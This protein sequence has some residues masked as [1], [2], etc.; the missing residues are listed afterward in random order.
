[1]NNV[2]FVDI[3]RN[4][5]PKME[6]LHQAACNVLDS[7]HFIGGPE[8]KNFESEMAAW[9]GVEEVC[10]VACATD[11][12]YAALR[13][14]GAG[15]GD[16]VITTAHTAIPSTEAI[17]MTG[18]Q[19]VFCDIE[20]G[21]GCYNIDAAAIEAKITDKTKVLMPV[22]LY[23]HPAELEPI[24]ALAKKYNLKLLEDCAQAQGARYK[25]EYVG[26]YGDAAVFSFFPSKN[27]GGFGDG[28]AVTARDPE[29]MKRVRMISNH[30][31]TLKYHHEIEGINSRLDSMQAALLRVILPGLD[32]WNAAR[33]RAA[34][35]YNEGLAGIAQVALPQCAADC[36]HIYHVYV[37]VVPD[38]EALSVH[39]KEQGISTGV[40]YPFALNEQPAYARLNQGTGSFPHAEYACKH[41][42]S[43]PMFPTI[44]KDEVD[45]V[46]AAIKTYFA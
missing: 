35:W 27:L 25:G 5:A 36:E 8:V 23:G 40:H 9:L 29:V 16:E 12:L 1:M 46:C 26:T 28:G 18:A 7:A 44:T 34:A 41:M 43:L 42:L 24:L 30:G 31:R 15:P 20:P 14:L 21:A 11:G 45:C 33:A 22:H 3:R 39:L 4:L 10:G 32:G 37:V 38:R 13:A 2:P 19:V 6:E 17:T